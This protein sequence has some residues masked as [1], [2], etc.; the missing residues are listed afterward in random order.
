[1]LRACGLI[2]SAAVVCRETICCGSGV[3]GGAEDLRIKC[4]S[5]FLIVSRLGS[6]IAFY[7][8]CVFMENNRVI[9]MVGIIFLSVGCRKDKRDSF[10][11][12]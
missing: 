11:D 6:I 5:N 9:C 7:R 3:E 4:G 12:L 8:S 2:V 1:M 10:F